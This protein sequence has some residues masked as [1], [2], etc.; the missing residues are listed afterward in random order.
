MVWH[1][2][3]FAVAVEIVKFGDVAIIARVPGLPNPWLRRFIAGVVA[4]ERVERTASDLVPAHVLEMAGAAIWRKAL[5]VRSAEIDE[6]LRQYQI[7][8]AR[9]SGTPTSHTH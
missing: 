9:R 4:S 1:G 5:A 3:V 8:D 6:V 2:K 7:R